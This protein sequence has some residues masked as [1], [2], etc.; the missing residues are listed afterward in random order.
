[1][2]FE[3]FSPIAALLAAVKAEEF[4]G[5]RDLAGQASV[6]EGLVFSSNGDI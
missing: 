5:L 6:D 3:I 4:E 2:H 1:M